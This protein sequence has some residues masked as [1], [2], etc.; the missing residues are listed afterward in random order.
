M[1]RILLAG[2]S[3]I[4]AASVLGSPLVAGP[5]SAATSRPAASTAAARSCHATHRNYPFPSQPRTFAAGVAGSVTIAP[6][7][8]GTIRV[9]K[10]HP[11]PGYRSFI[12]TAR[13]SSVDV[14]FNG[15]HRSIKFEAEINDAGG[16]TVTVSNCRR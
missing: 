1:N 11:A 2:A 5:A 3:T 16:L 10:V 7:N 12:D 4:L 9:A 8:S 15:H 13:G 6:V 14:Y